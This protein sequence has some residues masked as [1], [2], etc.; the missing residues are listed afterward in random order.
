VTAAISSGDLVHDVWIV[1]SATGEISLLGELFQSGSRDRPEISAFFVNTTFQGELFPPV[2]YATAFRSSGTAALRFYRID[3]TGTPVPEETWSTDAAEE[4]GVA[5]LG[6]AGVMYALRQADGTVQLRAL[7]A[8]RNADNTIS[9]DQVSQHTAP[10]AGTLE[11]VRL[12][13]VHAEGDYVTAATEPLSQ[14]LHLRGYRSG[15]RP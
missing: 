9:A 7:D 1:D 2:Y 15:D 6:L 11:L 3:A 4:V 12:P 8:R 14:A 5:P 10:S 13:S